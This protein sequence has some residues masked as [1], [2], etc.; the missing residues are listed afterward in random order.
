MCMGYLL[1]AHWGPS[2]QKQGGGEGVFYV[3][4]PLVRL[5]HFRAK[6]FC[7]WLCLL[8]SLSS[9]ECFLLTWHPVGDVPVTCL[10]GGFSPSQGGWSD[11]SWPVGHSESY[12]QAC[13]C[14]YGQIYNAH[15]TSKFFSSA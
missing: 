11:L 3:H 13:F 6:L 9:L 5:G 8:S 15:H 1:V 12:V 2:C 10:R 7:Y 14:E 4:V